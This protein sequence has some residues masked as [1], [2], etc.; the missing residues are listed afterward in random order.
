[1]LLFQVE[2]YNWVLQEEVPLVLQDVFNILTVG[3]HIFL[4][5][6]ISCIHINV[7]SFNLIATD[8]YY[9]LISSRSNVTTLLL[10][11][12]VW[13]SNFQCHSP[14]KID[15]YHLLIMA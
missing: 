4:C 12:C 15:F 6:L 2:E 9:H 3:L 7:T 5:V 8:A 10:P 14:R 1:L 13:R 11:G